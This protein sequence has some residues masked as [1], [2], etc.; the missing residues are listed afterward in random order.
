METIAKYAYQVYKRGSFTKAARDLYI[1]QPSLSAAISRLE[2]DL[3]FRIFDRSTVPCAL[4]TEGRIYIDSLEEIIESE[5][6]MLKRIKDLSDTDHGS[7]SV[8]GSSYASYLILSDIC[9][10]FHKRYPKINLTVD[11]GNVGTSRA[12]AEKLD[13]R[14]LDVLVTY[15]IH[16]PKYIIEPIFEERL[17]IAMHRNMPGAEKLTHLAITRDEI[18]THTYS[19]DREIEDTSIFN[20]IEFL[21]FPRKSDTTQRM[22]SILGDYRSSRCKIQNARHSEMHY[23]LMCAGIGAVLTNTLTIAQ[24]PYDENILF[25]MPKSDDSYRRIFLAYNVES[26]DNQLL[27]NFITVAKSIYLQKPCDKLQ[28]E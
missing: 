9:S 20:G 22:S 16:N 10:E 14:E 23:N 27:K 12:L 3:G 4:T 21:E 2:S 8:G 19:L 7:I 11:L 28:T 26:K 24:K 25:F 18:L 5:S 13:T 17:I 6:N 1:S 15:N